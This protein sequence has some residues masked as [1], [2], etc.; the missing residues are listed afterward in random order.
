MDVRSLGRRSGA[1]LLPLVLAASL[2]LLLV[3]PAAATRDGTDPG[4]PYRQVR[5][6]WADFLAHRASAAF[7]GVEVMHIEQG[8]YVSLL[9]RNAEIQALAAAG[10][11][12]TVEIADLEA[13]Y[14]ERAS[15]WQAIQADNFGPFHTYSETVTEMDTIHALYPAI[16][17]AR[18]AIGT[19]LQG[20]TLWAMKISDNPGV[21]EP[22]EPEVLFDGMIHAREVMTVEVLL[23]FMHHLGTNYGVDPEI[24]NLVDNR[25]I[26]FVPIV[27]PDG[28]LYNELTNPNGGGMWRKNRRNDLG[29]CIGVDLNRNY[30]YQ[31]VGG[32]S[33]TDPCSDTYRGP[34]A[35]SE[36]EIQ[37]LTTFM[38]SHEFVTHNSYHSVAGMIL[39]PWA[40]TTAHT[41]DDAIFRQMATEMARAGAYQIG[42]P[43]E[44]LYVVNGGSM[45]WAYGDTTFKP[46]IFS[47]TTEVNGSGFWPDPSE[48]PALIAE[49]LHSNIYLVQAAGAYP[50]LAGLVVSG[51]NGNSR[52][53]PGETANLVVTI[54]N[55]GVIAP[56]AGVV[57]RLASDDAYI[58]LG[59]AESLIGNIGPSGTATN[60]GD[61]FIV[62][63]SPTTPAGYEADFRLTIADAGGLVLHRDLTLVVGEPAYLYFTDFEPGDGGWT[64][65]PAHTATTGAFVRIDPNP[66]TFQPGDDTT[67][68]PGVNA[69]IT[70][71]NSDVGTD[72]VD[73]GVSATRSPVIDLS[74]Q[75]R[76]RLVLS[77]FHGQR[78][79]G[80]DPTGDYFRIQL[81]NDGGA[82]YPAN[83]VAIGDVT[84]TPEWHALDVN[85][86]TSLPLTATMRI[87]VLAADTA[88]ANDI[89]EGGIDDVAILEPGSGNLPPA[90]PALVSPPNGAGNLPAA[91]LL[92]VANASD[93]EG[94]PLTYGFRVY[95]DPLLSELVRSVDGVASG[96]GQTSWTVSPPLASGTYYWRAYAADQELRGPFM[97]AASFT[98]GEVSAIGPDAA[99]ARPL[100]GAATPNPFAAS[101]A[102]TYTL[103]RAT[104]VR[105]DLFDAAGRHVRRLVDGAA[106]AGFHSVAWDGLDSRG[107]S[108]GPGVYL[109]QLTADGA[110]AT[111]KVVRLK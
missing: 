21:E 23:S 111:Q 44:I 25:Q 46:K 110:V 54:R 48:A 86:E 39:F 47:F 10:I 31:W 11:P 37:A 56:A 61:P 62:S 71:Q 109:A 73:N 85:L 106:G 36:P 5:I 16:T 24:T 17:T 42:Q 88:P 95:T 29:G 22:G 41:A 4:D 50:D 103:E 49:N 99:P 2:A 13:F 107:A 66:T 20:N 67:P 81:S 38:S 45:D 101:T 8:E 98:V 60:A 51:G 97:A 18:I 105:L 63:A 32:G 40:Y 19:T 14:T 69:W 12:T 102:V 78:D 82:T 30:P 28:Y 65:D 53:D 90:A 76:A 80:D 7:A 77:Y 6:S 93:P 100:L 75:A 43:P 26:W 96:A 108:V 84:T 58:E 34:S 59:A 52:L 74:G 15:R 87:R 91:P 1:L 33:S 79:Q 3:A 70:G 27:N 72:D 94:D 68:A 92:V 55:Q 104:R 35:G 83:L 64:Q 57:V 9:A 89:V